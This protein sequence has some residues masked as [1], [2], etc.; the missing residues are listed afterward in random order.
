MTS[1]PYRITTVCLGN[2][3]RS[4]MAEVVLRDRIAQAGFNELVVVDSAGTGDW[5]IDHPAD[6]R[7]QETLI[8]HGYEEEVARAH[9]ARQISYTWMSDIDLLLTM[10][11][12]N[13]TNV[14]E[15]VRQSG[16]SPELTMLR[17]FDPELTHLEAPHPELDVPDPYFGDGDGFVTVLEMIERSTEGLISQQPA[18]LNH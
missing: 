7:A 17:S 6:E 9:R 10:D 4:P 8:R 15:M 3:C 12:R 11:T 2:I 18:R 13:Y 14:S 16:H 1:T 5:H